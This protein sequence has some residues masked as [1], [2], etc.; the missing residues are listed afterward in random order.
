MRSLL[1]AVA[2]A[3]LVAPSALAADHAI[4]TTDPFSFTPND[5]T[6]AEGDSVTVSNTSGGFHTVVFEDTNTECGTP[7]TQWT[8]GPHTYS[9]PGTYQFHCGIHL[10]AMTATVHVPAPTYT[11][12]GG[13]D[14]NWTTAANWSGGPAG[15]FPGGHSPLDEVVISSDAQPVLNSDISIAR[16]SLSNGGGRGGTGKL[17]VTGGNATW[18]A[19]TLTGGVTSLA[20]GTT[21]T[22]STVALSNGAQLELAGTTTLGGDITGAGT[23]TNKGTT[24]ING[25]QQL[26]NYVQTAGATLE[27][28][29]NSAVSYGSMQTTTATLAGTL[30]IVSPYTPQ[31]SDVFDVATGAISGQFAT[32]TGA[33]VGERKYVATYDATHAQL[34]VETAATPTPTPTPTPTATPQ[35]TATPGPSA[36]PTATV[37]PTPTIEPPVPPAPERV[38]ITRLAKPPSG[39]TCTSRKRF[40]LV[41]KAPGV[42]VQVVRVL[43]NGV[44][45]AQRFRVPATVVLKK[46]PQRRFT[47]TVE[48]TTPDLRKLVGS[49][50]FKA[51]A[52]HR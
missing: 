25:A 52:R 26:P 13:T 16:L 40:K 35:E 42:A 20:I 27:E 34:K 50:T 11:W 9:A 51:C 49:R 46:L 29:I 36:T 24:V 23:A 48:V 7:S 21:L 14:N 30:K 28:H 1:L 12:V 39:K 41:L 45:R 3:L 44:Q 17:T 10:N 47:L 38:A 31:L 22:T 43:V 2:A 33:Q 15:T 5:I 37:T 32:V 8:C 19:A 18:G 6:I 4:G